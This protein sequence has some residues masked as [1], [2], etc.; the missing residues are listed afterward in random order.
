[1]EL[2]DYQN[3]VLDKLDYYLKKL[4]DTKEEAEDFVAFQKMKGKEARL[5]DY[6]KDTW[7][8]LVQERRIDLLKD[9]SGHLVPAPY[10]TRFD[11][12]ERPI[13]N[14]CLKVPTGGGKTL[15]GVAAVERLQTDLF[16]QQTGMVL[17]VVPSDAIYKQ[18]WKQLAN[19]EHPYRQ[20][21]ERASGGR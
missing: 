15:L 4:A 3:G 13:P 14:V 8:A 18:T 10:V 17:W 11:G 12:L 16:A 1:M 5:T 6:A 21:L 20:M 2:K 7:E 9:K 19:R